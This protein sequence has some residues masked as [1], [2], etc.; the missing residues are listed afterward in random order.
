MKKKI[1]S[2]SKE[3]QYVLDLYK[4]EGLENFG[5]MSSQSWKDDPRAIGFTLSRYKF[6]AKMLSG[7]KNVL[8][9]GCGD[10]FFSR[11]VKQEVDNLSVSDWDPIFVEQIKNKNINEKKWKFKKVFTH[12]MCND[13]TKNC[14]EAIYAI[15]VFEHISKKKEDIF[16]KNISKSLKNNHSILI[17]GCPSIYS[18]KYASQISKAGH[19]NCKTQ[20][21]LKKKL[22]TYFYNTFLFS[23]NDEVL[24]TGYSKMSNYY[25][26]ICL[27]KKN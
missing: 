2:K 10:A 22:E 11:V 27:N 17:L 23:M 15:D 26:I 12:D 8:E 1:L 25:F 14:Y 5:Y 21:N 9:I 18:Q 3:N 13:S 24:H 4:K 6:V 20:E 19:V 7:K 16:L